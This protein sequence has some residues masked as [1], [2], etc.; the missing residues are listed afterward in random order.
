[1]LCMHVRVR[2]TPPKLVHVRVLVFRDQGI[3]GSV[4]VSGRACVLVCA[5]VSSGCVQVC[6][7]VRMFVCVL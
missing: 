2:L 7:C 4:R 6:V 5:R 1:M 3:C